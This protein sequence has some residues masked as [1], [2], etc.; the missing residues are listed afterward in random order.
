VGIRN[1]ITLLIIGLYM[2]LTAGF[3]LIRV[4]PSV[5]SGV[6]TG[7]L[8]LALFLWTFVFD[9]KWLPHFSRS[10]LLIP[11]IIWWSLGIG[12][13]LVAIPYYF[14]WGIVLHYGQHLRHAFANG[15]LQAIEP[16]GRLG[17]QAHAHSAGS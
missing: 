7:E 5:G 17:D 15:G 3:M 4:P 9:M 11:F 1:T 8:L 16:V 2:V 10:V 14:F 6:P 12:R 13:A